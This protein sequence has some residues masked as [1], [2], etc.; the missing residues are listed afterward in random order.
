MRLTLNMK[1]M[2]LAL[3]LLMM[4]IGLGAVSYF[5]MGQVNEAANQA[6]KRLADAR[7]AQEAYSNATKQYQNQADLIINRNL[8]SIADFNKSSK[9]FQ[10]SLGGI[11]KMADT[12][13]EK[14]LVKEIADIQ[15]QFVDKFQKG[16]VPEIKYQ[17]KGVLAKADKESSDYI[18]KVELN[19]RKIADAFRSRLKMSVMAGEYNNIVDQADQ[20][21]SINQLIFW[22]MKQY[23]AL[24]KVVIRRDLG[25]IKDYDAAQSNW[26]KVRAKVAKALVT[27]KEKKGFKDLVQAYESFDTVFRENVVPAIE[28]EMAGLIAKMDGESDKLLSQIED[29]VGKVVAS[30]NQEARESMADYQDTAKFSRVLV[31][32]ISLSATVFGILLGVLLAR[33]ITRPIKNIID[34]LTGGA[35]Q[36]ASAAAQVSD[37]S[38]ALAQGGSEQASSLE[39]TSATMEQ[40]ASM[41]RKNAENAG[42]ARDLVQEGKTAAERAS[43]SMDELVTSMEQITKASEETAGI[44]KAIDEIAFQTNLLALNAAVEAARAGEAGAGFAVVADE[45]RNLALRAAEAANNISQLIAHTTESTQQGSQLV[46]RT[47]DDF[48][49]LVESTRKV[50]ELVVEIAAASGEQAQ[51]LEQVNQSLSQIDQVTQS[52]A[53]SAEE[54]AAASEELSAQAATMEA[55][56]DRLVALVEGRGK[57]ALQVD[58]GSSRNTSDQLK[59]IPSDTDI[60]KES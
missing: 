23:Q 26:D 58:K 14:A 4:L 9:E 1:I 8:D 20:L 19:A 31:L 53:A 34:E 40:M 56:V 48:S 21:D 22:T 25:A 37:S 17:L 27:E 10:K 59:L 7:V 42:Q 29:R 36:V 45:V 47:N 51:G 6:S 30:I 13:A 52:N 50:A 3:V 46:I 38:Q 32:I 5:A 39:E 49:G 35:K 43:L 60:T 18:G 2:G 12:S 55:F 28:H 44:I 57:S 41:T 15:G 33:N 54:S 11:S 24:A 16:V